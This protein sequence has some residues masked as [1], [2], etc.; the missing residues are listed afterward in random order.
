MSSPTTKS[1]LVV[2]RHTP[3]GSSLA[4]SSLELALAAASFGQTVGL[5]FMGDGVLQLIPE[6]DSKHMGVRNISRLI[7]SF[8]LYELDRVFTDAYA[9][10]QYGL[11]ARELVLN[12]TVLDNEAMQKLMAQYD[13]IVGF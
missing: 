7:A 11:H 4:R 5:L 13:H 9:I 3:Y 10:E 2:V 1:L 8:P 12:T 6:Q